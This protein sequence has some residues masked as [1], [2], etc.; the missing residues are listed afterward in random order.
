M[1][2]TISVQ[3]LGD[4]TGVWRTLKMNGTTIGLNLHSN[5]T[6]PNQLLLFGL[7]VGAANANAD[8]DVDDA[9]FDAY[10]FA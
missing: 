1:G 7:D 6:C 2:L 10:A 9:C 4:V 3:I 5:T 8:A